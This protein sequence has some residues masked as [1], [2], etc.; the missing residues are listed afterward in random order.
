LERL[1]ENKEKKREKNS[2][3]EKRKKKRNR[4]GRKTAVVRKL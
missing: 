4:L 1:L 3:R 2:I